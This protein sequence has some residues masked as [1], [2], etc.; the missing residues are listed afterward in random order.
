MPKKVK[1]SKLSKSSKKHSI[2]KIVLTASVATVIGLGFWSS[3]AFYTVAKVIDGDTFVTTEERYIRLD[4]SIDAPEIDSCLGMEA[5]EELSKLVVGKKIFVKA[6][7][8]DDRKRLIGS[9]YTVNGD[10]GVAMLKKGLAAYD[11]KGASEKN[12]YYLEA[13]R[14]AKDNNLGIYSKCTQTENLDNP[15][16]NIKGN[17]INGK[18]TYLTPNCSSYG[19]TLIQLYNGD[20]WFC[21]QA[22]AVKEGFTKSGDCN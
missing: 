11:N 16:C 7:Y 17:A 9:V 6:D 2:K 19:Q 5:K 20:K 3:K 14:L 4:R 13:A 21:T 22:E 10:V 18:K 12:K 8:V 1:V 15:K